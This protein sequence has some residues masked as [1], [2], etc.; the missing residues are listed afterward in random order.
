[1]SISSVREQMRISRHLST[2]TRL[3]FQFTGIKGTLKNSVRFPALALLAMISTAITA[4]AAPGAGVTVQSVRNSSF[5][6]AIWTYVDQIEVRSLRLL[7]GIYEKGRKNVDSDYEL[8]Q[9][10][11]VALGDLN[12]DGKTDAAVSLY[13]MKDDREASEVAIVLDLKGVPVHVAT[14]F[15]GVGTEIM[16]LSVVNGSIRLEVSNAKYCE[17]QGKTVTYRLINNKLV[18]PDPFGKTRY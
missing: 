15:F 18:G 16:D 4:N 17:G 6:P 9:I 12:G 3:P 11:K 8:L 13:H 5:H 1:M 10:V 2:D 14:R 7:N